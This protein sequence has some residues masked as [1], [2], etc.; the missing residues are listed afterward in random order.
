MTENPH[1]SLMSCM[2][3]SFHHDNGGLLTCPSSINDPFDN[4]Q[5]TLTGIETEGHVFYSADAEWTSLLLHLARAY[6]DHVL[7]NW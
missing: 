6:L 3:R 1:L 2:F 5:R 4:L 7:V